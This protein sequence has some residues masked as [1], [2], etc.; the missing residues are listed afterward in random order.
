M[1]ENIKVKYLN[2][3]ETKYYDKKCYQ[4]INFEFYILQH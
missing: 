4:T 2:H 3:W 1:V